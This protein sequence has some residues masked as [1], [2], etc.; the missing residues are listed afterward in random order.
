MHSIYCEY[1]LYIVMPM[2]TNIINKYIII[3]NID[4]SDLFQKK[5]L[6]VIFLITCNL[7]N[8]TNKN[9]FEK[10]QMYQYSLYNKIINR[11][12]IYVS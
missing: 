4:T 9:F 6:L 1:L 10:D 3:M 12:I 5:F 2:Y 11:S 8:I 7:R